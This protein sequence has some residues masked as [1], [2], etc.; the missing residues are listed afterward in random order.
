MI[1]CKATLA[2]GGEITV[3]AKT[4]VELMEK[5]GGILVILSVIACYL[6]LCG[7]ESEK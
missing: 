6:L 4:F 2:K 5:Q 3:Y 7:G 1:R